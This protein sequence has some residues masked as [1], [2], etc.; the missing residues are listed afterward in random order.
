MRLKRLAEGDATERMDRNDI[1]EPM[2]RKWFR[3]DLPPEAGLVGAALVFLIFAI[4]HREL[5]GSSPAGMPAIEFLLF[6]VLAS[7][8]GASL[9]WIVVHAG[10]F[11]AGVSGRA[12]SSVITAL[13]AQTGDRDIPIFSALFSTGA[14][15]YLGYYFSIAVM[16]G[17]ATFRL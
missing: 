11:W 14:E 1:T 5:T 7:L 15:W 6:P 12:P 4:A 13:A 10:T 16:F 9:L 17:M 3:L 2:D 8:L